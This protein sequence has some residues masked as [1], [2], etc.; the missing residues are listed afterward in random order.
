MP[1]RPP[2]LW[3]RAV[4]RVKRDAANDLWPDPAG[5]LDLPRSRAEF[6]R[7]VRAISKFRGNRAEAARPYMVPKRDRLTRP[8]HVLKP[9]VRVYFQS[10]VDRFLH[11]ADASLESQEFVYGYRAVNGRMSPEPFGGPI[12]Q[13]LAMRKAVKDAARTGLY[14][15]VVNTDI[16]SFFEHIDHSRLASALKAVRVPPAIAEEIAALLKDLGRGVSTTRGLPQGFD[17]ASVLATIFLDP[18][19]KA[20][21]RTGIAYYRYVDDIYMLASNEAEARLALR[22]LETEIRRIG[23]NLQPGKTKFIVGK[24]NIQREVIEA[25]DEVDGVDYAVKRRLKGWRE[26]IRKKWQS[27]SKRSPIPQRLTKY[28]VNRM[29][30]NRDPYAV[31]WCLGRLGTD[32]WLADTI[33]PYLALFADQRRVQRAVVD[34]LNSP[35]NISAWEEVHLLRAFLSAR[36]VSRGLLDHAVKVVANRNAPI[37]AR[38]WSAVLIGRHGD[39]VDQAIL[40]RH[41]LDDA[42]L[43]RAIVVAVQSADPGLRSAV[44]SD[45][46]KGFPETRWLIDRVKGLSRPFWPV[47]GA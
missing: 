43:A 29:R 18:V 41:H 17:A 44:L 3:E 6:P 13:W 45:I 28:L 16:A 15:A 12:D 2:L 7:L 4:A 11:D 36:R 26:R 1:R 9:I 34:H 24:A 23:L 25:D 14:G 27:A 39:S 35:M 46:G 33:G 30:Y 40:A 42:D 37:P 5:L 31:G 22:A 32:D 38:Q 21:L 20:M 19:D 10:L 47:F 8:G